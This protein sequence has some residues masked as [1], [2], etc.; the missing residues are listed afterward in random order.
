MY[1]WLLHSLKD[2][3]LVGEKGE[4]FQT[5]FVLKPLGTFRHIYK[6][7][8]L[9]W[10]WKASYRKCITTKGKNSCC[11]DDWAIA[12]WTIKVNRIQPGSFC[13]RKWLQFPCHLQKKGD[14]MKYCAVLFEFCP[15][16]IGRIESLIKHY[17]CAIKEVHWL[18]HRRCKSVKRSIPITSKE[19]GEKGK[20]SKSFRCSPAGL[21]PLILARAHQLA[22]W[23]LLCIWNTNLLLVC[24]SRIAPI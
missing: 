2:G 18:C 7:E 5:Y 12:Q 23:A 8:E 17:P 20:K 21:R 22:R 1:L 15:V 11:Q 4:V 6:P 10:Y 16:C 19:L 9:S 24:T 3:S 13:V 14:D